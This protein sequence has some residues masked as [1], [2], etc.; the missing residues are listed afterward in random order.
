MCQ[1]NE[2]L[3]PSLGV[4]CFYAKELLKKKIIAFPPANLLDDLPFTHLEVLHFFVSF[5][6]LFLEI[7]KDTLCQN[8]TPPPSLI[9]NSS[10]R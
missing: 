2:S 7:D 10:Q 3:G 1:C 9:S 8:D 4:F 5:L 6:S